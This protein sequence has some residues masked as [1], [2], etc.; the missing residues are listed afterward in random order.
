MKKTTEETQHNSVN[1][2]GKNK[3]ATKI[4]VSISDAVLPGRWMGAES[5]EP[6]NKMVPRSV[7]AGNDSSTAWGPLTQNNNELSEREKKT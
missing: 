1:N 4:Y 2:K 3:T 5:S 6:A 7:S